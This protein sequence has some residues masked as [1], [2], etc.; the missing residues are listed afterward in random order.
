MEKCML[1]RIYSV[2]EIFN[3]DPDNPENV[4]MKIP[5][6]IAEKLGWVPGDRLKI[7]VEKGQVLIKKVNNE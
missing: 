5:D 1:S 4:L 2:D 7:S 6:E 3:D